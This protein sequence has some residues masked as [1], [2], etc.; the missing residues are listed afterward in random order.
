MAILKYNSEDLIR[1]VLH[2]LDMC[3][4]YYT[5]IG[6]KFAVRYHFTDLEGKVATDIVDNDSIMLLNTI[7]DGP[8]FMIGNTVNHFINAFLDIQN[9]YN[10]DFLNETVD[11]R[12]RAIAEAFYWEFMIDNFPTDEGESIYGKEETWNTYDYE[13]NLLVYIESLIRIVGCLL[14]VVNDAEV[15]IDEV[16]ERYGIAE[17]W[18]HNFINDQPHAYALRI[19]FEL[20]GKLQRH[21]N[22]YHEYYNG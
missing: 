14:D 20:S 13:L 8:V 1:L 4:D 18:N 12:S 15:D 16:Y 19:L 17:H 21:L 3:A 10:I 7:D 2:V 22:D 11:K 9:L 6:F 5:G